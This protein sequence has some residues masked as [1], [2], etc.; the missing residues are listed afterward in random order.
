MKENKY[1]AP[2]IEIQ[3]FYSEGV[4]CSSSDIDMEPEEGYM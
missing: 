2:K 4:L 1:I 3:E